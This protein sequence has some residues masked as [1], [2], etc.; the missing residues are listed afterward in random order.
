M[1][2]KLYILLTILIIIWLICMIYLIVN[3][4]WEEVIRN[5]LILVGSYF[6]GRFAAWLLERTD[7]D[8]R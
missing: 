6:G 3:E 7:E 5:L 4:E 2:R 8:E 1:P